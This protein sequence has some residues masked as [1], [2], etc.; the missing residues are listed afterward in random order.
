VIEWGD[1][2]FGAEAA[3]RRYFGVS[4]RNLST[5]QAA[6]LAAIIP[7]PRFYDKRGGTRYLGRRTATIQARLVQAAVP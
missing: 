4:A 5:Y 3:A 1:G 6:R 7:N 2:V